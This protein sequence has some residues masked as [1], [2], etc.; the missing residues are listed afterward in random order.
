MPL[1][2]S[3]AAAR[4]AFA[5]LPR[6][7]NDGISKPVLAAFVAAHFGPPGSD[8]VAGPPPDWAPAPP[9][10][11]LPSVPPGP[12]RDAAVKMH[13]LWPALCCRPSPPPRPLS[14][15]LPTTGWTVVPG[16]RFRESY[17]WD[18]YWTVRGL[19]ASGMGGTARG[20]LSTLIQLAAAVGHV[21][22]G[23]RAYYRGRSQP[24]LLADVAAAVLLDRGGGSSFDGDDAALLPAALAAAEADH[25]LWTSPPRAVTVVDA[26]GGAHSLSRYC[27]VASAPRPES[28]REDAAAAAGLPPAAHAA[29]FTGIASACESGWDFSSR[30]LAGGVAGEAD[31]V[32]ATPSPSSPVDGATVRRALAHNVVP[33]DLNAFLVRAEAALARLCE[34]VGRTDDAARY[35]QAASTRQRSLDA[36]MWDAAARCWR[37]LTLAGGVE[38]DEQG[39]WRALPRSR[40]LTA[41]CFAPL[42]TPLPPSPHAGDAV[43]GLAG[44]GLVGR[45]GVATS[46]VASGE[47]WDGPNAWPPLQAALAEGCADAACPAG[48]ALAAII[49][50]AFVANAAAGVARDGCAR[51]KY[52]ADETDGRGG[53]GGEYPV[54]TGFGWSIGAVLGLLDRF[55]WG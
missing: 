33:V 42:W 8:L 27:A 24:P 31:A 39:V 45:G 17:Y 40:A 32:D 23:A 54:Q 47:Q 48:A 14:T 26:A 30:W 1:L 12:I 38:A 5:A 49:V 16:S 43:A 18:A 13:S 7:D 46:A 10:T 6:D 53:G 29:L 55:G 20:V 28:W 41:A 21:P 36:L 25:A 44:S 2:T 19:L 11:F 52:R 37:D 34:A 51:E 9:P 4:A 35:R 15:L 3:P 22:N 50:R